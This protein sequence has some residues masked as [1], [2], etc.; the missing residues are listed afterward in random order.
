M[1]GLTHQRPTLIDLQV[2]RTL[3]S[4][5]FECYR[6]SID[7]VVTYSQTFE[8]SV[9]E[10]RLT[11]QEYSYLHLS[12]AS[13][14]N[15]IFVD[16]YSMKTVFFGTNMGQIMCV[17]V[18]EVSGAL[19]KPRAV[20]SVP[21]LDFSLISISFPTIDLSLIGLSNPNN[22]SVLLMSTPNRSA[23]QPWLPI[24][25]FSLVDYE[26]KTSFYLSCSHSIDLINNCVQID[27][28]L[29]FVDKSPQ[30]S[31][32]EMVKANQSS[33][34]SVL[35]WFTIAGKPN[36]SDSWNVKR[37]RRLNGNDWPKYMAFDFVGSPFLC[38]VSN[39]DFVFVYD[40]DKPIEECTDCENISRFES[41]PIY[42]YVQ[43]LEDICVTFKL[44]VHLN[45]TDIM[46]DLKPT[47]IAV[48][49]KDVIEFEG[50][51]YDTIEEN[52]SVWT[53]MSEK[54]F[55]LLEITVNKAQKGSVWKEFIKN[56]KNGIE[57]VN[58][59]TAEDIHQRLS[60]LTAEVPNS[61]TQCMSSGFYNPIGLEECDFST[62]SL[63]FNRH[64]GN[65]H[66]I[67][68]R[69]DLTGNQ[70]LFTIPV[71]KSQYSDSSELPYFVV[72]HDVDALVWAPQTSADIDQFRAVHLATFPAIGY[73]QA[74]KTNTRFTV[75]AIN[76]QFVAIADGLRHVYVYRQPIGIQS[77]ELR[78]RRTGQEVQTV[79]NQHVINL[80]DC[81]YIIG[82]H[83]TNDDIFVLS[84]EKVFLIKI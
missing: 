34:I 6:V 56:D 28:I 29:S 36:D 63:V 77:G 75:G 21:H 53:L 42:T 59:D 20:Y 80:T 1:S 49:I 12:M 46:I 68:H 16:P 15:H 61:E 24:K 48:K 45:K 37:L 83:A 54:D 72:R 3:L 13:Q 71:P 2:D 25:T 7:P 27:F 55:Q 41:K 10:L 40:S 43:S 82:I 52:T 19:V 50:Q 47:V 66:R 17:S 62:D 11:D 57:I 38:L 30:K 74:S 73:V 76:F 65:S 78:N 4:P 60:Q 9:N 35:N 14:F 81:Q 84:N 67:S 5:N 18:E 8:N 69:I 44:P 39:K 32:E 26:M 58:K 33:F 51:L 70:W 64:N 23:A 79:A 22:P 31:T